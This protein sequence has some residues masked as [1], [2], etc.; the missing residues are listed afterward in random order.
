MRTEVIGPVVVFLQEKPHLVI[1]VRHGNRE[2]AIR[3]H[4]S[5]IPARLAENNLEGKGVVN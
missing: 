2:T 3:C 5:L 4:A 1:V